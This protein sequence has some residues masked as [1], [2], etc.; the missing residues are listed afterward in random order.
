M[1]I[2]EGVLQYNIICVQKYRTCLRKEDRER[3][4]SLSFSYWQYSIDFQNRPLEHGPK[5]LLFFVILR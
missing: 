4:N 2:T 5:E 1:S 3:K